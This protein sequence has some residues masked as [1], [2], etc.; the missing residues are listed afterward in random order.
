MSAKAETVYAQGV[1]KQIPTHIYREKMANPYRG[2]TPDFFYEARKQ[3]WVEYKFVELPK[4]EETL[5]KPNLS[6]LQLAWLQRCYDNGHTAAVVIGSRAGGIMLRAPGNW[7][8]GVSAGHFIENI[9][10]KKEMAQ[11][12]TALVS[13]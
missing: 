2:G 1:N 13:P 3:A 8:H 4:R 9:K 11:L 12:I 5:I 7:L 10:T 6:A